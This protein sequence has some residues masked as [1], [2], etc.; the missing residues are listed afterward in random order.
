MG[1]TKSERDFLKLMQV[2]GQYGTGYGLEKVMFWGVLISKNTR[3]QVKPAVG[4]LSIYL[5]FEG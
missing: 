1:H 4:I 2:T 5:K 3:F